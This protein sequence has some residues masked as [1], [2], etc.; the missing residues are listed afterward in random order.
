VQLIGGQD[1]I[2]HSPRG[3]FRRGMQLATQRHPGR[4]PRPAQNRYLF[5]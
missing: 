5:A 3:E 4:R 1:A 2:D